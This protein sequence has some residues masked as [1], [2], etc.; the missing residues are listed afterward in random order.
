MQNTECRVVS[1]INDKIFRNFALFDTFVKQKHW[2]SPAIFAA[3]MLISASACFFMRDAR[4]G[5]MTLCTVLALIGV[6]LPVVYVISFFGSVNRQ[7]N[8]LKL[9]EGKAAYTSDLK[10]YG[11]TVSS[12]EEKA[13][14][15]W[16]ALHFAYLAKDC[17][18]L[19]VTP[20]RAY[21][22]PNVGAEP[23][24]EALWS[25]ITARLGSEKTAV[26]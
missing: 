17:I 20:K 9:K 11:I 12:G 24:P 21:L 8:K 5:A 1:V 13:E 26:L 15:K 18:Y 7:I 6:A 22:L 2:R 25:L 10:E 23:N 3:I 16:E 19:Y 4:E 14:L